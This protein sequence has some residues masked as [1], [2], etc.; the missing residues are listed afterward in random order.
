MFQ[1][2][3][4]VRGARGDARFCRDVG[5]RAIAVVAIERAIAPIA[6]EEIFVAVVIVI[7]GA[8][9]LAPAGA[10]HAGLQR[11]I[12]KGAVAIV[13]VQ[14]ADRFLALRV[15]WLQSACR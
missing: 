1:R 9:A 4:P 14:A 8:H 15:M 12:G 6:D 13:F 10:R 7:A 2:L 11:D 5:E 3:R